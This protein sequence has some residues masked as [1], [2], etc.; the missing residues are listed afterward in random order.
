MSAA[1][2]FYSSKNGV[3]G[4]V[5]WLL[6]TKLDHLTAV[7]PM[8]EFPELHEPLLQ[9]AKNFD[10]R[11]C[12]GRKNGLN[13]VKSSFEPRTIKITLYLSTSLQKIWYGIGSKRRS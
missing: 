6:S 12:Y 9:R 13:T 3:F 1:E 10:F 5:L 11:I 8:D 7:H 2:Y 4:D